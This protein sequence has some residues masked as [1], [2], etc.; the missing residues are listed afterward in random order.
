LSILSQR[1]LTERATAWDS[2]NGLRAAIGDA[3]PNAE[4]SAEWDR[5]EDVIMRATKLIEAEARAA[6]IERALTA[7][8][9]DRT[10][11]GAQNAPGAAGE[12]DDAGRQTAYRDA[13][14]KYTRFGLGEMSADE[15]RLLRTG[16]VVNGETR[17][18]SEGTTT[19]GGYLVP[20]DYWVRITEVLKAYGGLQSVSNNIT[21]SDGRILPWPKNDDTS[22]T[23]AWLAENVQVTA[24]D[25]AF[26]QNNL[27]AYTAS[28]NL[29]LVSLE[30]LQDSAFDLD[31]WI[32]KK[33]GQRLGRTL[34]AGFMNGTGTTQPT[35]LLPNL[36]LSIT[37]GTGVSGAFTYN[38]LVD[39]QHK[40]DPAYRA[41][42]NCRWMM[43]DTTVASLLKITD[44]YGHPLWQPS[45]SQASPDFL[46]GAPLQ[47]DQ[48]VA[49]VG[50]SGKSIMF[51]DFEAGYVVRT[52]QG[53]T[54][55]RL[56]ERYADY[57]QVG[58]F[59]FVRV[60]GKPDDTNAVA[61]FVGGAT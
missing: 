18:L 54:M 24:L 15:Q 41:L 23:G 27:S 13:F 28:S 57:L 9:E 49:A 17:A 45:I 16:H 47:I 14:I 55:M 60:D 37:G 40:V 10:L 11:S 1:A 42:G 25:A 12:T 32:P 39:L 59:G 30:L 61:Y 33:L 31:S 21:T 36:T 52:V 19:A 46:L 20:Q 4:Q 3:L 34:A 44:N 2:L 50:L 35:G 51:G 8:I 5:H 26:T 48:A 22:N 53:G 6:D 58:F 29:I 56:T 38:N 7:P 43:N